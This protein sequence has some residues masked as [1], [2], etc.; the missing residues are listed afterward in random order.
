MNRGGTRFNDGYWS[1]L[2]VDRYRVGRLILPKKKLTAVWSHERMTNDD[3]SSEREKER[4][5][6]G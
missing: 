3:S 1:R 6:Q 2:R 5:D 4:A